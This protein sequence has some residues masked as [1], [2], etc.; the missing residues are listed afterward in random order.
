MVYILHTTPK[1]PKCIDIKFTSA[2][3]MQHPK[4]VL[5]CHFKIST[6]S[7]PSF[8]AQISLSIP[9]YPNPKLVKKWNHSQAV[10]YCRQTRIS[11]Q[12]KYSFCGIFFLSIFSG[13]F[14]IYFFPNSNFCFDVSVV[15]IR[16]RQRRS[17]ASAATRCR[18]R[19][20]RRRRRRGTRSP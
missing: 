15:R 14:F 6:K 2:H 18:H 16:R 5:F 19:R 1:A 9:N 11:S 4:R 10:L 12:K 13:S 3:L 20:P 17:P 7:L 8:H